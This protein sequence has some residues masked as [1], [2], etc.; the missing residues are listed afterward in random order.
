MQKRQKEGG[1]APTSGR[2]RAKRAAPARPA[3]V[4]V[5]IEWRLHL[6]GGK[7]VSIPVESAQFDCI[8]CDTRAISA[9]SLVLHIETTHLALATRAVRTWG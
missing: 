8:F 7:I 3:P 5:D 1:E 6:P 4:R 9:H 2:G